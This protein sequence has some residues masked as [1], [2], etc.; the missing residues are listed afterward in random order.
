MLRQHRICSSTA[1]RAAHRFVWQKYL[2]AAFCDTWKVKIKSCQKYL[3]NFSIF[4][5]PVQQVLRKLSSAKQRAE[6]WAYLYASNFTPWL[7]IEKIGSW[8]V[9]LSKSILHQ[10]HWKKS[11][12]SHQRAADQPITL[13]KE[14]FSCPAFW[15]SPIAENKSWVLQELAT[16]KQLVTQL[17]FGFTA[18]IHF[19]LH[20]AT[21]IQW[22]ECAVWAF[23]ECCANYLVCKDSS[24]WQSREVLGRA[25]EKHFGGSNTK[26]H[27]LMFHKWN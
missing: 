17:F 7:E 3:F 23:W 21:D 20:S 6:F 18:V 26:L 2:L 13:K 27:C 14:A 8:W 5:L 15:R 19:L 12:P 24:S 11:D 25:E 22:W 4:K 1:W 9:S 10:S 16:T